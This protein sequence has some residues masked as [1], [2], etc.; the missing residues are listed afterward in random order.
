MTN[1]HEAGLVKSD[2]GGLTA[3]KRGSTHR[4]PRL[5]SCRHDPYYAILW[6]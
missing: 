5:A 4:I 3:I 6:T 1:Q 2:F